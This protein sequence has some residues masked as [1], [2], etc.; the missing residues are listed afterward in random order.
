MDN[1]AVVKENLELKAKVTELTAQLHTNDTKQI[2]AQLDTLTADL[3][4][5]NEAK[6]KVETD[7]KQA[8]ETLAKANEKN[9]GLETELKTV[10]DEL[11]KAAAEKKQTERIAR[12]SATLQVTAEDATALVNPLSDL[13]DE[14]FEAWLA[15]QA[16]MTPAPNPPKGTPAPLPPQSTGLTAPMST[17]AAE[18]A[19]NATT[20][21]A[22]ATPV[23]EPAINP[24][25][26]GDERVQKVQ[27]AVAAFFGVEE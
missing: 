22:T 7:L 19:A 10:K 5:A 4:Q 20:A 12:A 8:T 23:Q 27:K 17:K 24:N 9:A 6:V 3:K 16:K 15:A 2:K 14:K 1:E 13:S 21:L 26:G 11:A 25:D 18:T